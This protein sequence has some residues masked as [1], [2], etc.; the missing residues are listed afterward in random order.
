MSNNT[1]I[2]NS[3]FL[4]GEWISDKEKTLS[5]NKEFIE[6]TES[7]IQLLNEILGKYTISFTPNVI[8]WSYETVAGNNAYKILSRK[9]EEIEVALDS[10]KNSIFYRDNKWL[11]IHADTT[12]ILKREYFK[13]IK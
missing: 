8:S 11:Y 10:D 4:I 9:D 6:F 13:R 3:N 1:I 2:N 7:Q 5:Y 12:S